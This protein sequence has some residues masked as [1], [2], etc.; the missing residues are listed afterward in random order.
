MGECCAMGNENAL[1]FK[2]GR[3]LWQEGHTAH[4]PK[5]EAV[6]REAKIDQQYLCFFC[7]EFMAIPVIQGLKLKAN[8]LQEL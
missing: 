3:V 8:A 6:S 5:K 4:A 1:V 2:N 7:R